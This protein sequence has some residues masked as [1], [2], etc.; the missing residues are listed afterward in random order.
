MRHFFFTIIYYLS[1]VIVATLL[2]S[3]ESII[4]RQLF[5]LAPSYN[6]VL[7]S[8]LLYVHYPVYLFSCLLFA[9]SFALASNCQ[10]SA[11]CIPEC[12]STVEPWFWRNGILFQCTEKWQLKTHLTWE[13]LISYRS[14]VSYEGC[15]DTLKCFKLE[16]G[17]WMKHEL[18]YMAKN[19]WTP[20]H[21]LL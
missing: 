11:Q 7:L 8:C 14:S 13:L 17:T 21:H 9:F 6:T 12:C 16:R 3:S 5:A 20:N 2:F 19:I 18:C 1:L 10:L 4:Y 15:E